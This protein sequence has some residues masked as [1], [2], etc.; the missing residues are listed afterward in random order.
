MMF[1]H[2]LV[3]L[4]MEAKILKLVI[5]AAHLL[6]HKVEYCICPLCSDNP[7]ESDPYPW[8]LNAGITKDNS[9][10]LFQILHC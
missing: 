8:T 9:F 2:C 6:M 5:S 3:E 4:E 10:E 1:T 7:P